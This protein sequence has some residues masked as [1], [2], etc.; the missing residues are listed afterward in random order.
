M[1]RQPIFGSMPSPPVPVRLGALAAESIAPGIYALVER[2]VRR[3]P[4]LARAMAGE[5]VLRFDEG[6]APV[7]LVF[8]ADGVLVE[9]GEGER[10][11]CEVCAS[12]PDLIALTVAPTVGGLPNPLAPRGRAAL[13]RLATGRVQVIGSRMLGRKLLALLRVQ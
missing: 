8:A 10:P 12:L 7:R 4:E 13:G 1:A 2:G 3:R 5:V 6:Y 9:D 11:D